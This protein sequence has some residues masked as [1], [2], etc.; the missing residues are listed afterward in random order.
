MD[1]AS[2][3]D[4]FPFPKLLFVYQR[5][6]EYEN[7]NIRILSVVGETFLL[8]DGQDV[9]TPDLMNMIAAAMNKKVILFPLPFSILKALATL[10]GQGD[11]M[12]KLIGSLRVVSSKI[13]NLLGLKSPFT[14]QEGIKETGK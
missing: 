11:V 12:D 7:F 3:L 1:S 6:Y 9:S 5:N 10:A 4:I 14:L 8:S 13:R 2:F